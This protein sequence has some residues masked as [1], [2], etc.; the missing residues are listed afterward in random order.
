MSNRRALLEN[1]LF[2]PLE[3][4][5]RSYAT[6]RGLDPAAATR[7]PQ[8][9]LQDIAPGQ[10]YK[11]EG[12]EFE[13]TPE[14]YEFS[15]VP[16]LL[17]AVANEK[18]S[19][20]D[21]LSAQQKSN[22][23]YFRQYQSRGQASQLPVTEGLGVYTPNL[24]RFENRAGIVEAEALADDLEAGTLPGMYA[25]KADPLTSDADYDGMVLGKGSVL[26]ERFKSPSS[27]NIDDQMLGALELDPAYAGVQ[28]GRGASWSTPGEPI[29]YQETLLQF[30]PTASLPQKS[31]DILTAQQAL[32]EVIDR[33][34]F[35]ADMDPAEQD[36]LRTL[37]GT[38]G[39]QI[40]YAKRAL[41]DQ[42]YTGGHKLHGQ[43][44]VIAHSRSQRRK[45]I[46]SNE[47]W[48]LGD[49]YQSDLHQDARSSGYRDLGVPP[50]LTL[51]EF[52]KAQLRKPPKQQFRKKYPMALMKKDLAQ[53]IEEGDSHFAI[54][55]G[56][57]Q[58]ERYGPSPDSEQ[59]K[60]LRRYYDVEYPKNLK[61][62]VRQY[63]GDVETDYIHE[64]NPNSFDKD[65]PPI[66]S[67]VDLHYEMG[68]LSDTR[69]FTDTPDQPFDADE[70]YSAYADVNRQAARL[71]ETVDAFKRW[72]QPELAE[73]A[74]RLIRAV[75]FYT[76][77]AGNLLLDAT[78][79]PRNSNLLW[80]KKNLRSSISPS[81]VFTEMEEARLKFLQG[82]KGKTNEEFVEAAQ[83]IERMDKLV[84][85]T[86]L[87][88]YVTT[89]DALDHIDNKIDDIVAEFDN[90]TRGFIK[91]PNRFRD[92]GSPN[93]TSLIGG[94]DIRLDFFGEDSRVTPEQVFLEATRQFFRD[95]GHHDSKSD[96]LSFL[97]EGRHDEHIRDSIHGHLMHVGDTREF[98]EYAAREELDPDYYL[99]PISLPDLWSLSTPYERSEAIRKAMV[100]EMPA[101]KDGHD[102][103]FMDALLDWT[104]DAY[105]AGGIKFTGQGKLSWESPTYHAIKITDKMRDKY[106]A[107]KEKTGA[108]FSKYAVPPVAGAL[109]MDDE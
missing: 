41:E 80:D 84:P 59:G 67:T 63:G 81:S 105:D 27:L 72:E 76:G 15:N 75:N 25:P 57:Q 104:N 100:D 26:S 17:D 44:D 21:L 18:V 97:T 42:S 69:A 92:D 93:M 77:K 65:T 74:R 83:L 95:S 43:T 8:A 103:A 32:P 49:E 48:R 13:V 10:K 91:R 23:L 78:D 64:W 11:A 51:R 45:R 101:P 61:R 36:A 30:D 9:W 7:T 39:K 94:E 52:D 5:I 50:G 28:Y 6:D 56:E 2:S 107:L 66:F 33:T 14:E 58:A 1:Y 89:E 29:S 12:M 102:D 79:K 34:T 62:L 60:G 87:K 54:T 19:A 73:E 38:S 88:D 4:I 108:G 35:S 16:S 90:L 55:T 68:R 40:D 20:A 3:Q 99:D 98:A 47:T 71:D 31:Q 109:L 24:D 85:H 37:L 106:Y 22:P 53:A 82:K 86:K 96:I 46:G 70:L